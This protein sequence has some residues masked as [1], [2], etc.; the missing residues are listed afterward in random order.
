[1]RPMKSFSDI[2]RR[3]RKPATR[4]AAAALLCLAAGQGAAETLKAGAAVSRSSEFASYLAKGG[5]S[6]GLRIAGADMDKRIGFTCDYVKDAKNLKLVI[7]AIEIHED[8]TMAESAPHPESG[9]WSVRYS[10]TRCG[11]TALYNTVFRGRKDKPPRMLNLFPGESALHPKVMGLAGHAVL[12]KARK[13]FLD[14]DCNDIR[15]VDTA[16]PDDGGEPGKTVETWSVL[17]CKQPIDYTVSVVSKSDV[18]D[19]VDITVARRDDTSS[20]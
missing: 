7:K 18:L 16:K 5:G 11:E 3:V 1:M 19:D 2:P 13:E 17:A 20:P 15:I 14:K 6:L 10:F 4:L 12:E 9:V 8:V